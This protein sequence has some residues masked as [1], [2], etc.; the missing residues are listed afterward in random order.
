MMPET[1]EAIDPETIAV[2]TATVV[3]ISDEVPSAKVI[4]IVDCESG[5]G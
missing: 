2:P 4:A 1:S 3:A 5:K